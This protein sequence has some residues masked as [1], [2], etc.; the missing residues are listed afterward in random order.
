LILHD[1]F[2]PSDGPYT[3]IGQIGSSKNVIT[4]GA[5]DDHGGM[6]SFSSYGPTKDGRI[7]PDIVA[8]GSTVT[9]TCP[10]DSYCTQSGTSMATPA[11]SGSVALLAQHYL[12]EMGSAPTPEMVKALLAGTAFELGEEGPEYNFGWGLLDVKSAVDQVKNDSNLL[13]TDVMGNSEV[14]EYPLTIRP[15]DK[16][17]RVTAAWTDAPGSPAAYQ[18]LVNDIDLALVDPD[19]ISHYPWILDK[20]HPSLPAAKGVNSVDNIEQVHLAFPETGEWRVMLTGA[21]MQSRPSFALVISL[22]DEFQVNSSHGWTDESPSAAGLSNGGYVVAWDSSDLLY[23]TVDTY[24]RV[25]DSQGRPVGGDFR[26]NQTT[27]NNQKNSALAGLS[28]GGFAAVWE[29]KEQDGDLEGVYGRLFDNEGNATTSEFRINVETYLAQADPSAAGLSG[30]GF[31]V[32]WESRMQDSS[33]WG[34]FTRLF[35]DRGNALTG[36]IQVNTTT[37]FDQSDP[38]VAPLTSGGFVVAWKSYNQDGSW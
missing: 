32:A 22:S 10:I 19:G 14:L 29:S 37:F 30:G 8:N 13:H 34:I 27:T 5:V 3:C 24:G 12:Q 7:K 23:T 25:F 2:H 35:D 9:S 15:E 28:R 18:A 31:V 20:D 11:V 16:V 36:D 33:D 1:D 6:T 17:V 26:L 4:V 21:S 38:C